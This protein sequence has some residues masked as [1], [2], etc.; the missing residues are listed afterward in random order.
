MPINP[1]IGSSRQ[2]NKSQGR[3]D[4]CGPGEHCRREKPVAAFRDGSTSLVSA[5][6]R[7]R[8]GC[9]ASM[10]SALIVYWRGGLLSGQRKRQ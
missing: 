2:R 6:E 9:I 3:Q 5:P 8:H 10:Q 1:K 7:P 4:S